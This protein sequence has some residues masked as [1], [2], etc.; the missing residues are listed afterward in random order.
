MCEF[1]H[2]REVGVVVKDVDLRSGE[3]FVNLNEELL[4]KRKS[5]A[6]DV[7]QAQEV[8]GTLEAGAA[9]KPQ[10]KPAVLGISKYASML[11]EKLQS[12]QIGHEIC[13]SWR[14]SYGGE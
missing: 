1:G 6:E 9:E 11:P 4:L 14:R 2:E 7:F 5:A 8:M 3:V 13:P 10:K 12:T